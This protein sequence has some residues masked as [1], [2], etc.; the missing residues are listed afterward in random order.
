MNIVVREWRYAAGQAV[1]NLQDGD[2]HVWHWR[3]EAAFVTGPDPYLPLSGDERARAA[4]YLVDKARV[5]FVATRSAL[6]QILGTYLNAPAESISF[7]YSERGKPSLD[8]NPGIG[9]NISH[10]EGLSVL[11]ISRGHDIG[12]DVEWIRADVEAAAL[13]E[14]FFSPS[15]R[16][17]LLRLSE[18]EIQP[19]FFRCWTRKEAYIKARGDGLSLALD[20]FDVS[21]EPGVTSALLRTRPRATEAQKW[22]VSDLGLATGYAAALA[23]SASRTM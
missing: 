19:A 4:R 11:A 1:W 8:L 2:V 10:S 5:E 21:L 18:N 15:E 3:H 16:D 17:R 20:S 23:W 14:R 6:R 7:R 12:V 22:I 9:F 13:A